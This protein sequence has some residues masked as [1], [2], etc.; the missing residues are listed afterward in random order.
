[1]KTS[2]IRSLAG[3]LRRPLGFLAVPL[4]ALCLILLDTGFRYLYTIACPEL[5]RPNLPLIFTCLWA[6]FFSGI[7]VALPT[8]PRR[9][10][11]LV[12]TSFFCFMFLV[13]G[14]LYRIVGTYFSFADL[15]YAGDGARFFSFSY[16]SLRKALVLLLLGVWALN[17][18]ADISMKKTPWHWYRLVIALVLIGASVFGIRYYHNSL[19]ERDDLQVA[20]DV[21]Y[22]ASTEE[23]VYAD[24]TDVNRCFHMVGGYQ[25]LF[26][27]FL[28]TYGIEDYL[29]NDQFY[30]TLDT[31]YAESDKN[32]HPDNEMTGVL[33]DKNMIFVL[34]ESVDTWLLTEDIM[35][36]L[37]KLQQNGVN[38][39]NHYAPIFSGAATFGTEFTANTGFPVPTNGIN[40][41]AYSTYDYPYALANLLSQ[42]GYLCQSFHSAVGAIYDRGSI[43][44]NLGY[45][46]YNCYVDM[47]MEDYMLDSQMIGGYEKMVSDDPF[48]TF[49]ITYS[50]HG[51]YTEELDN[52]SAPHWDKA[53]SVVDAMNYPAQGDDLQE[54]Y[55]AVAHAMETDAF[56]GEL[57]DALTAD[58]HM[59][60]TALFFF[61]D[62]WSK[63][64]SNQSLVMELKGISDENL[65]HQ[66]PCF[67]YF[68][69]LEP[70]SVTKF[71]ST[72]DIAPTI[73]NLFDLD[74]N[75]AY[76]PGNDIFDPRGDYVILRNYMWLDSSGL[77]SATE[78]AP[79]DAEMAG[80][81]YQ[82]LGNAWNTLH[83][84]YFAHLKA[85]NE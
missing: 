43:H 76:Y 12:V 56:I 41:K 13:H 2:R 81:V 82:E 80:K 1:M 75:Y 34:L 27:S 7:A 9:I 83:C 78:P 64:M 38:F 69:G 77:H 4:F 35:P 79:E 10:Y 50:G 60:D 14:A 21:R 29:K 25:Y 45:S 55:H 39:S 68:S 36:N 85:K 51:P 8:L 61:T 63:Y 67:M 37:Y 65:I 71:T 22:S 3:K 73:A 47:N 62:H 19:A 72:M 28:V 40:S 59:D 49:I 84:N 53:V 5:S 52:I 18:I 23:A 32:S 44:P 58:G 74:V 70:K 46:S 57:V 66:V 24:L 54:C 20:W 16:I 31:Y 30:D 15:T 33:K 48:F 17:L 26:K 6:L 11:L 42:Q